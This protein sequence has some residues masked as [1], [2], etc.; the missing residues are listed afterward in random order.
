[1]DPYVEIVQTLFNYARSQFKDLKIYY[2]H[3]TIYNRVWSD[4]QRHLRAEAIGEFSR[5]DPETRL[6]IVGDAAMAPYELMGANGSLYVGERDSRSSEERLKFLAR[7]F[8][9]AVWLNPQAE[10]DWHY[11]WTVE[12]IAKIFPMFELTLDGL[13]RAVRH[14]MKRH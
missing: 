9:H 12:A 1:M 8:R 5:R 11:T 3:N 7:L 4:P 10:V 2:F 14:L 6:I 13:E